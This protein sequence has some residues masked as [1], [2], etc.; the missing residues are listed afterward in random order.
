MATCADYRVIG[1]VFGVYKSPVH[2]YFHIVVKAISKLTNVL[3]SIPKLDECIRN[4]G[5]F[6][7]MCHIPNEIGAIDGTHIPV[8]APKIG[9]MDFVNRK[10]WTSMVMQA[11]VD[12]IYLFRDV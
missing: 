5:A 7:K 12:N 8:K 4:A 1:D 3:I 2:K 9:Y 10:G 11:V 6:Q